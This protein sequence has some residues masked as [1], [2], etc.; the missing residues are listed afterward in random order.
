MDE[1]QAPKRITPRVP[2]RLISWN[3]AVAILYDVPGR[4]DLERGT[5]AQRACLLVLIAAL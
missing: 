2:P 1:T 4:S 5:G 3:I